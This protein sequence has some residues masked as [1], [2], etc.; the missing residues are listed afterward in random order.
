MG[1]RTSFAGIKRRAMGGPPLVERH[2]RDPSLLNVLNLGEEGPQDKLPDMARILSH[3]GRKRPK[4][5]L[6]R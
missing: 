5:A 4:P 6:R 1:A 2:N 3:F